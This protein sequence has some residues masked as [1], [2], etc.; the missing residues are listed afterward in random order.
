[1]LNNAVFSIVWLSGAILL[2]LVLLRLND[3]PHR[4]G[5]WVNYRKI[6]CLWLLSGSLCIVISPLYG[7]GW[8]LSGAYLITVSVAVG[9][10]STIVR[11]LF[12][13]G[14]VTLDRIFDIPG[15]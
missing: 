8:S 5:F 11:S 3:L 12:T 7:W 4:G 9:A 1:M 14:R 10:V 2:L 15:D 13:Q 6:H